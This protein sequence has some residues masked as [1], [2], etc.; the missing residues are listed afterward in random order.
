METF[1]DIANI[2]TWVAAMVGLL[3]TGIGITA[4][5]TGGTPGAWAILLLGLEATLVTMIA[6]ANQIA[7]DFEDETTKPTSWFTQENLESTKHSMYAALARFGAGAALVGGAFWKLGD[8]VGKA[9]SSTPN[10]DNLLTNFTPEVTFEG[11]GAIAVITDIVGS[12]VL[13]GIVLADTNSQE[14]MLYI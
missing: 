10:I 13:A 9:I 11:T 12:G 2:L 6:D 3:A 5:F 7:R 8:V 4:V 14:S 1:Q